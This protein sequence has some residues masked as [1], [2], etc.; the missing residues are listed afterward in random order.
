MK[1]LRRAASALTMGLAF[2]ATAPCHAQTMTIKPELSTPTMLAGKPG[3]A[4]LRVA[5]TGNAMPATDKRPAVNIAFVI[6]KSGSMQGEKIERAKTAVRMAI[7]KLRA[8]DIV[9]VVAYD[10]DVRVIVPATRLNDK[11]AVYAAIDA[12]TADQSTA[13]FAGVS[14][15]A[16]EIRKFLA[17]EQVNRI[18]LMSDGLANVGP[19][20][21]GELAEL[22]KSLGRDGI[23][24]STI[25]LGM[26]YNEDLMSK[27]A[28]ASDGNH[29]FAEQ[30]SDLEAAFAKEFGDVLSV[31]AQEIKIDIR[32]DEGIRPVR[33]LG[34]D[35]AIEGQVAHVKLNQVYAEQMKYVVL[36]VEIPAGANGTDRPVAYVTVDYRDAGVAESHSHTQVLKAKFSDDAEL[37]KR[38]TNSDVMVAAV[39]QIGVEQNILATR[40]RDEGKIEEAKQVLGT[41]VYFLKENALNLGSKDLESYSDSNLVQMDGVEDDKYW[42]YGRK[43][44]R[45]EQHEIITQQKR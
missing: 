16:A 6:D 45:E 40:L 41:N 2:F 20:S 14:K 36:E 43:K 10:S 5:L 8:Q 3:T 33:I 9:S 42:S 38:D 19:S 13:L 37:V 34:R 39:F 7:E 27:L 15:G 24:V 23:V 21:P 25:G 29:M 17:K 44:A 12:L 1:V 22:G 28:S 31:A 11:E 30:A 26:D 18:V 4:Y 35:G 32:C